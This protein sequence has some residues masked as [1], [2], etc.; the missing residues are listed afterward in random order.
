MFT[1]F[2]AECRAE[3]LKERLTKTS[4]DTNTIR[5]KKETAYKEAPGLTAVAA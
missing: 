5:R 3:R 4:V 1:D 2:V